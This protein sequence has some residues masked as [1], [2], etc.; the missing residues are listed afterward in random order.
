MLKFD[1]AALT[2]QLSQL[3]RKLRVIFAAACAERLA[4][5]YRCFVSADGANHPNELERALQDVWDNPERTTSAYD[6]EEKI[7]ALIELIP[8]E[9]NVEAPRSQAASNAESAGTAIVYA[10]RT[11]LIG[12]PREAVWAARA[13]YEALDNFI[14]NTEGISI[15]T[16]EGESR[17]LMHPLLQAELRRQRRDLDE[18]CSPTEPSVAIVE[19]LR[20]RARADA[21][22]FLSI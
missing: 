2:S 13:A 16:A 7:D 22:R 17:V 3:S 19:R 9:E 1:E 20:A 8:Q 10:L 18:L 5:A 6:S 14:I 4:P 15:T 11:R 12:G 21:H